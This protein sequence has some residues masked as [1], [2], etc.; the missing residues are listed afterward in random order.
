MGDGE[1][2]RT[3]SQLND[4]LMELYERWKNVN[5]SRKIRQ[6]Q[7]TQPELVSIG[8]AIGSSG[9]ALQGNAGSTALVYYITMFFAIFQNYMK[10]RYT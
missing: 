9:L 1:T 10:F 3:R 7:N 5:N 2:F 4:E 6:I 8:S